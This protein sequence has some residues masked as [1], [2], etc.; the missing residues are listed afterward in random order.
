MSK[1]KSKKSSGKQKRQKSA[2]YVAQRESAEAAEHKTKLT[3]RAL[4]ALPIVAVA[5]YFSATSVQA[6]I[7]EADL[8]K[9]DGGKPSIVQ[10]HDPQCQLCRT[11]QSQARKAMKSLDEGTYEYL[12]ANIRSEDG[13]AFS[14]KYG[15]PHVTLL[16]FDAQ[17]QMVE[18]VRGPS[19]VETLRRAFTEHLEKHS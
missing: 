8:S 17:G 1:A 3:R 12:V 15:V 2:E 6:I 18:I 7:S 10:I 16:L 19:D 14:S 4:I 9:I 11:L 5:G 13:L